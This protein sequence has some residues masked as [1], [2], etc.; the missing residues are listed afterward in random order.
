ME[1]NVF[2]RAI[3][4]FVKARYNIVTIDPKSTFHEVLPGMCMFCK[5]PNV[6]ETIGKRHLLFFVN[7]YEPKAEGSIAVEIAPGTGYGFIEI[8][9]REHTL[10]MRNGIGAIMNVPCDDTTALPEEKGETFAE[11]NSRA[12]AS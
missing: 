5:L 12:S 8:T 6:G 7:S 3:L 2:T 11:F 1:I 10:I 9:D 4:V